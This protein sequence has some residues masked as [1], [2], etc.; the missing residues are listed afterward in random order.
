MPAAD[1]PAAGMPCLRPTRRI[2]FKRMEKVKKIGFIVLSCIVSIV[3]LFFFTLHNFPYGAVV[4]RLD[5]GLAREYGAN[6]SVG[7][8]EHRYPLKVILT[9][10][11]I[12][13]RDGTFSLKASDLVVRLRLLS[14]SPRKTIEMG[15]RGIQ[16][17]TGYLHTSK[18]RFELL[19]KLR[20]SALRKK[21]EP[22]TPG[23]STP[24][25][26]GGLPVDFISLSAQGTE[27]EK[28]YLSGFEFSSFKVPVVEL[29]LQNENGFLN[30]KR[31]T[32]KSDLFGSEIAGRV[33]LSGVDLSVAVK[34]SAEFFRRYSDLTGIFNQIGKDGSLTISIQGSTQRPIVRVVQ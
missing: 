29:V 30:V 16:V 31:G 25:D 2:R 13:K 34:M 10:I 24:G 12:V 5:A 32:V 17:K 26:P 6:L 20:L 18:S 33:N 14:F 9:D 23:G 28:V 3:L 21:T 1:I 4:K 27:V 15:G 7:A 8:V 22:E 19:S 11:Q